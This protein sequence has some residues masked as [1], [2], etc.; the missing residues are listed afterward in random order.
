MLRKQPVGENAK[1]LN[2]SRKENVQSTT[3]CLHSTVRG[4]QDSH[5]MRPKLKQLQP[6]V[7]RTF[8]VL[9]SLWKL[10]PVVFRES[11][12]LFPLDAFTVFTPKLKLFFSKTQL[13]GVILSA[14][15][16]KEILE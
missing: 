4:C 9:Y 14:V 10:F 8:C 7:H 6:L 5:V 16:R 2:M 15:Y 13:R 1:S 11:L 3:N 12:L